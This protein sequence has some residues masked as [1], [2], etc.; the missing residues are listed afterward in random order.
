M[1]IDFKCFSIALV[2]ST[3]NIGTVQILF[4]WRAN[5]KFKAIKE[6]T[7]KNILC[8][9]VIILLRSWEKV[10]STQPEVEFVKTYSF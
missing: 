2:E 8:G 9:Q 10:N 4:I 6:S 5:A 7:Y 1:A 3:D